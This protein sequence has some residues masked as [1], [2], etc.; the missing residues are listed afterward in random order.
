[1]GIYILVYFRLLGFPADRRIIR[2][3]GARGFSG[4]A[5][6]MA[7]FVSPADQYLGVKPEILD[8]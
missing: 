4:M 8:F 3:M 7:L 1:M 6:R 2:V 5:D